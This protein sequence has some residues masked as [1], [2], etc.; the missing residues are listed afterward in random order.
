MSEI[1]VHQIVELLSCT[2]KEEIAV[3]GEKVST[4]SKTIEDLKAKLVFLEMDIT[5]G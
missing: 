3:L 4:C 5:D 2:I 1:D